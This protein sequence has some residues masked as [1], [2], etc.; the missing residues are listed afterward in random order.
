[1]DWNNKI[2]HFQAFSYDIDSKPG[3]GLGAVLELAEPSIV[4]LV[5]I[6][7]AKC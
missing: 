7:E 6:L 2:P 4:L 5:P 1:M 3:L